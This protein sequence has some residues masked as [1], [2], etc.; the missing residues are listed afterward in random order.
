M[1]TTVN[2][3]ST[4]SLL[5][6]EAAAQTIRA[7]HGTI[8]SQAWGTLSNAA[9]QRSSQT[10]QIKNLPA[11]FAFGKED[12]SPTFTAVECAMYGVM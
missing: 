7:F 12:T 1:V 6:V 5:Q 8:D 11:H 9:S 4:F 2:S 3:V 10:Y